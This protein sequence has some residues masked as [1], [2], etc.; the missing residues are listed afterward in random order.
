MPSG[1]FA[2]RLVEA[3]AD[4]DQ[5]EHNS[6]EHAKV[7]WIRNL[8]QVEMGCTYNEGLQR[9]KAYILCV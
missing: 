5:R 3:D 8:Q 1:M 4:D 7:S 6:L 9:V 2:S